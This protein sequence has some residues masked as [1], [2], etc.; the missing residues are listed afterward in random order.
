HVPKPKHPEYHAPSDDDIQV[1]DD[2][3]DLEEDPKE[4]PSE[5]HEPEDD[6]KDLEEDPNEEHEPE[7]EDTGYHHQ[8]DT[9]PL[10]HRAAMICW[11][12]DIIEEDMLP[13]RRFASNTPPPGFETRQGLNRSPG[14]DAWTIARDAD[15]ADDVGYVRALQAYERRMMTSIE[16]VNLRVNYQAQVH[17]QES[18]YLY[19]QLHD[20]QTDR[21]DIRLKIY[22][23]RGQRTAY[24]TKLQ[25]IHQAYLSSED[26]NRGLLACLETLET[27]V[28]RMEWQRQSTEDLEVT[29]MMRIHVLELGSVRIMHV[30]RQG[31]NDAMTL[32]S[33]QA[34]IDQAI[35]RKS[36][37][38][39]DDA[40]QSSGEG[41]KR[42]VQPARVCSYIDFMKCQPLNFKGTEGHKA[43]Y[44]MTWRNLKKKMTDKY[45]PKGV[46]PVAW[47]PYRLV[48]FQMKELAEQLQELFDKGFIRPSSSPW[49]D[50]VLFVKKK[51]ESFRMCIDYRELNKLTVQNRYP[52]PRID[53]L[54]DQLQGSSVYSKNDLRSGNNQLRVREEDI[55]KTAFRTRYGH[56]EFQVL[57]FGLTN[58][59]ADLLRLV[60]RAVNSRIVCC[61]LPST[62]AGEVTR[63]AES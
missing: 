38:T 12:A 63:G 55:P 37:H 49:G 44:A 54:F 10:G 43:A 42:P 61:I 26:Q 50:L 15:R 28:S 29:Q 62:A 22:I 53:D 1:E 57:P 27:H 3:E 18:K 8:L 16:E 47:A 45:C 19:T 20:A 5:E 6:D 24:E 60:H 25:E 32:E 34:M 17:R 7:D 41:L 39:Q 35:Q 9:A 21:K 31:T 14:H 58:A 51:D 13:R 2:D 30:T 46:A 40:S 59:P 48:P 52:L 4:S 36:T 56:C 23:V 33:I 11:R